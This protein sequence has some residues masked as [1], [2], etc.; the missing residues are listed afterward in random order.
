VFGPGDCTIAHSS[1]EYVPLDEVVSAAQILGLL[2]LAWCE[3]R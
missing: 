3:E 1:N 2:A